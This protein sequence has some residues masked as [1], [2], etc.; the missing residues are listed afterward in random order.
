M[1]ILEHFN[2]AIFLVPKPKLMLELIPCQAR[3]YCI[4]MVFECLLCNLFYMQQHM[5]KCSIIERL[6]TKIAWE[7]IIFY[8][9]EILDFFDPLPSCRS[10]SK[11]D[12]WLLTPS[13]L[14]CQ[15]RISMPTCR[16]LL[17]G[18]CACKIV[19]TL[20]PHQCN[21]SICHELMR[22]GGTEKGIKYTLAQIICS[23]IQQ[24]TIRYL[25]FSTYIT[26]CKKIT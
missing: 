17:Q 7:P 26:K 1:H 2:I 25:V 5:T 22:Q 19:K 21:N 8:A 24:I 15:R 23:T 11:V 9:D 10:F 13:P 14:G 18:P 4:H 3:T 20:L 16:L 12:I 6:S